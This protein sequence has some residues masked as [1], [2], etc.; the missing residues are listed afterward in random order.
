MPASFAIAR[1]AGAS[2]VVTAGLALS[3][4]PSVAQ[5]STPVVVIVRVAKPWYAPRALVASRMRDT[6]P[7]YAALPGL[8]FKAYSFEQAS[9]DFGGVYLWQDAASA[10]DWFNAAWHER[11]LRERGVTAQVTVLD[12]PLTLDNVPGGTPADAHASAVATWV[13]L[14]RPATWTDE[15]LDAAFRAAV[16]EH[17]RV[18]GLLRKS[19]VRTAGGFGGVYLWRD[20]A[21]ARAWFNA[22]WHARVKQRTATEARITWFDTPILL[23]TRRAD[24]AAPA[25][26]MI[27]AA[28]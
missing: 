8:L 28:P 2:L 20:E 18:P 4:V 13:D 14:P 26:T 5:T 22:D 3:A 11:V 10:R 17:Q 27:V 6:Q 23:P 19:F 9:G 7:E 25:S 12:A 15:A 16:P 24:N 21:A 1:R